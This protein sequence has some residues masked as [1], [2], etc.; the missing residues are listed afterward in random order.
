MQQFRRSQSLFQ[1]VE[2]NPQGKKKNVKLREAG[3]Q[4]SYQE[5]IKRR[6]SGMEEQCQESYYGNGITM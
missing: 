6:R 4:K 5:I 2:F 3:L 1:S